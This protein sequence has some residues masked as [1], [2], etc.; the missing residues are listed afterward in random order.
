M[1]QQLGGK[2]REGGR[3]GPEQKS[4]LIPALEFWEV[5]PPSLGTGVMPLWGVS[6]PRLSLRVQSPSSLPCPPPGGGGAGSAAFCSLVQPLTL[7]SNLSCQ[8]QDSSHLFSFF[9]LTVLIQ[10]DFKHLLY[11]QVCG[12]LNVQLCQQRVRGASEGEKLR[13]S[14][15]LPLQGHH[16]PSNHRQ[17]KLN[18]KIGVTSQSIN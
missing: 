3:D 18:N 15:P 7:N 2:H 12:E 11:P 14:F 10:Q 17:I 4:K 13:S 9:F 16:R 5:G 6:P 1:G 8:A